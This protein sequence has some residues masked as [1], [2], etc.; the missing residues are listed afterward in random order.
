MYPANDSAL[1]NQLGKILGADLDIV[2]SLNNL[3]G[4]CH[5]QGALPG[6]SSRGIGPVGRPWVELLLRPEAPVPGRPLHRDFTVTGSQANGRQG[7]PRGL[8]LSVGVPPTPT[9]S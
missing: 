6:S 9:L 3:D 8:A 4:E 5:S 7:G 1:V 2:M